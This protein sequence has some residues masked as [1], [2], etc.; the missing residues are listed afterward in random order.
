MDY[1]KGYLTLQF[2]GID[3]IR[4]MNLCKNNRL[5]VWSIL[6]TEDEIQFKTSISSFY[7]MKKINRKCRGKLKIIKKT[8]LVFYIQK[9]KKRLWFLIG[10]TVFMIL[11][12][13]ISLYIW[14]ISFDG[15]Y[16]YTD[17]ELLRFL[18][19]KNIVNGLKKDEIDCENIE[20][21]IRSEYNDIT[22]VSAEIRGTQLIIHMKENFDTNIAKAE[23]KPYNI[24][25]DV[26]GTIESI[27]T[28]NGMPAIK[29]GDVVTKGQLLVSGVIEIRNDNAEVINYRLVNSDADI[30]AYVVHPYQD[31]FE[32]NYQK[33]CYTGRDNSAIEL[34]LFNHSIYLTG[35]VKDFKHF[36]IVKDYKELTLTKNFYL[37]VS[38]GKIKTNEYV[39]EDCIYSKEEAE[40]LAGEKI[41]NYIQKLEQKG[42][43]IIENN[44]KIE[45]NDKQC[46]MS[47]NFLI[48][49]KIGQIEYVDENALEPI[50]EESTENETG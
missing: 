9:Y 1:I 46:I 28:R 35:F 48:L 23:D 33:K 30:Y 4:F 21:L 20:Y 37:P 5:N 42:I 11:L 10:M 36:D 7:Q 41:Q 29:K 32:L 50:T 12:K 27:I 40:T 45:V 44:V 6:S 26:D 3:K 49:Q 39:L 15:N 8:G 17:V 43:Q 38:V 31:S 2:K 19:S 13:I 18:N 24:V 22:W 34:S 47:G 16:S 25:S 14:N